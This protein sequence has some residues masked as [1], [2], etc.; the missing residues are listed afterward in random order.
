MFNNL[1]AKG[2][3]TLSDCYKGLFIL[4]DKFFTQPSGV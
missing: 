2:M 3:F 1:T 4:L